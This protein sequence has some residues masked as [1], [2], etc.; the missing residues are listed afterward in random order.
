MPDT[1]A[2]AAISGG[3]A[4]LGGAI[5]AGASH[6]TTIRSQKLQSAE[7][8]KRRRLEAYQELLRSVRE[9]MQ[10]AGG[11]EHKT[12]TEWA[13]W[14]R[15]YEAKHAAVLLLGTSNARQAAL[16]VYE[17]HGQIVKDTPKMAAAS[18]GDGHAAYIEH[19]PALMEAYQGAVQ[20]MR[21]DVGV[22]S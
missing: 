14:F 17:V 3:S 4:I 13:T 18:G 7:E 15:D 1:V 20:A 22:N 5:G 21:E 19:E 12:D 2:I 9:F 11:L 16:V 10:A 6:W 8:Y